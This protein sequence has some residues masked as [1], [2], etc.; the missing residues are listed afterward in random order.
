MNALPRRACFR[1]FAC[2]LMLGPAFGPLAQE[3]DDDEY[4]IAD[5]MRVPLTRSARYVA[6]ELKPGTRS[7]FGAAASGN[8]DLAVESAPLLNR[9]GVVLLRP[10][11]PADRGALDRGARALSQQAAVEESVPVYK[12]GEADQVLVNEFLVQFRASVTAEQTKDFLA[13]HGAKVVAGHRTVTNRFTITFPDRSS[14]QALGLVNGF[15]DDSLIQFAEPNFVRIVPQR[16]N[17]PTS[18]PRVP[19]PHGTGATS[20]APAPGA[21]AP[22]TARIPNDPEFVAN[23]QWGLRN[24]ARTNMDIRAAD[25]WGISIGSANVIIAVIDEGVDVN[26]PDLKERIVTPYDATDGDDDQQPRAWNGHGTACAGIAA[27]VTNNG[28]GVAGVAW[29]S[30]ILPVRIAFSDYRG[31][32][33]ITSNAIIE[34]GLREAVDRGAHVLSNSWGGGGPSSAITSAVDY[35]VAKGRV[36]V[37]AAGN[38]SRAVEY[39]ATLAS[40]RP[41]ITVSATNEWDEF[42]TTAS[43]DGESWWGSNFGPEV[44]LSAPGVHIHTTDI[45]GAGGYAPGDYAPA[46]NGTSSATP[47][48]AG[49]AA[50]LLAAHPGATPQ[51]V[52][53][54]LARNADDLGTQGFDDQF[55]F[56]RLNVHA[57][58]HTNWPPS[59]LPPTL[60]ATW[61]APRRWLGLDTWLGRDERGTLRVLVTRNNTPAQGVRV[62]FAS[63]DP[64]LAE[65]AS[66]S[67]VTDETGVATVEVIGRTD[68]R[69]EVQLRAEAE[70]SSQ[71]APV[72]VPAMPLPFGLLLLA[73]IALAAAQAR[74][75]R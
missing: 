3:R 21:P 62:A 6:V 52:R 34:D 22:S 55:G 41:V 48:V 40:S 27:A 54:Q 23:N 56:G 24:A 17:V 13:R 64:A 7:A 53:D 2:V 1:V 38:Y 4:Y 35:A 75:V 30:R 32:P 29:D 12:V 44:T 49:A 47:F 11:K 66:A 28:T 50:L 31:G 51:S 70:G 63:A 57:A 10:R 19:S 73:L 5:G 33:W 16:P 42:K 8:P 45:S 72:R 65:V 59:A 36:V 69:G 15:H 18:Q 58:L 9:F 43:Q 26:H 20:M 61:N 68:S 25:A 74:G 60:A 71:S 39:P 14:L 67:T 37:F 46:F